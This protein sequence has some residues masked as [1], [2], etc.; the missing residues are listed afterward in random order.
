MA[1]GGTYELVEH[2]LSYLPA[3][4]ILITMR[5]SKPWLEI[6]KRSAAIREQLYTSRDAALDEEHPGDPML[7]TE[8]G[9]VS[10]YAWF[11]VHPRIPI[12]MLVRRQGSMEVMCFVSEVPENKWQ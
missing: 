11:D 2:I 8:N 9:P 4:S 6:I 1:V 3:S 10:R 5:V 7:A 12:S